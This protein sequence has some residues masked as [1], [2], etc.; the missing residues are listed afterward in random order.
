M[1]LISLT[2]VLSSSDHRLTHPFSL[3]RS[4]QVS[5]DVKIPSV[6]AVPIA[7]TKPSSPKRPQVSKTDERKD[8]STTN[9]LYVSAANAKTLKNALEEAGH[10]DK[11]YRMTKA[12]SGPSLKDALGIIAVPITRECL[13]ALEDSDG[14]LPEWY[15]L[16]ITTGKQE[17]PFSTAVL[18]R[19]KMG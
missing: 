1:S 2:R 6:K 4:H 17:V 18:G 3:F 7:T 15:S 9:V 19:Q 14:E 12:E 16:V 10:L 8:S 5:L 11:Q 13:T